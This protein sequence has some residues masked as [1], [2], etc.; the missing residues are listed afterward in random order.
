MFCVCEHSEHSIDHFRNDLT[1]FL[2]SL[3]T[4]LIIFQDSVEKDSKTIQV[5]V[6]IIKVTK[7]SDLSNA[8]NV[9]RPIEGRTT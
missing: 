5:Y 2:G 7:M 3:R 4:F 1:E 6:H 9:A 8:T